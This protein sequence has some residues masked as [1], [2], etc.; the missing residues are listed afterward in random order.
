[1]ALR[2]SHPEL[3]WSHPPRPLCV[4][5]RQSRSSKALEKS[6]VVVVVT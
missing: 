6:V 4:I 2:D 3:L 1:M 5:A